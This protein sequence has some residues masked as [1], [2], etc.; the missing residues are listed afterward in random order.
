MMSSTSMT[1]AEQPVLVVGGGPVGLVM[2]LLLAQ[3]GRRSIVFERRP[4]RE[5]S[6]PKAH[7]LNPR[8]LE[9]CRALGVD[10]TAMRRMA[11][12]ADH[13][14]CAR[15]MTTLTGTE[16]GRLPLVDPAQQPALAPTPE[17]LLNLA[18]PLFES[19]LREQ[20]QRAALV[21]LRLGHRFVG[22]TERS[23]GVVADIEGPVG[24]YRIDGAWLVGADGANSAVREHLG[25]AM[26]GV[27]AVRPR[28]TIHFEAD[29]SAQVGDRP[30]IL[31]WVLD[32]SARGTFIAYDIRRTWVFTPRDVPE[33][34]D[35][36][37][38][39]DARCVDMIRAA[40][41]DDSVEITIRHVV[42][43]MMAAQ[44][45]QA[46]RAGRC[47]L[48]G[49]AA[50]RFPPTGGFGL[51]TGIQ[52]AHNLAWKLAAVLDG[53]ADVAL[54]DSYESERQPVAR[55]NTDR[56]LAN[57]QKLT[58]LFALAEEVLADGA[59]DPAQ[60]DALVAELEH[61]REH[62]LSEGLQLGFAYGPPTR[63][64]ADPMRYEPSLAPGARMPH[65][66]LALGGQRISTLDLLDRQR[67]SL[68]LG[69][70]PHALRES[71]NLALVVVPGAAAF[72]QPWLASP[73]L[74]AGGALLVRPDGH[75]AACWADA[76]AVTPE[77]IGQALARFGF[78]AD[79]AATPVLPAEFV[80]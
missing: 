15:F 72:E 44:V 40:L 17:P 71:A 37:D 29:L 3:H 26:E 63:G 28:I 53:R 66:W 48:A 56:S 73:L 33:C 16:F 5:S 30:A 67:F 80:P 57:A 6:A 43:W 74:A 25:I 68:L 31:Y 2:A 77:A 52:D 4:P 47:F 60:Q 13:A 55:L 35:R 59:P 32:P 45:A 8:S 38:Y 75:V 21:E 27:P 58:G 1:A 54:L 39:P 51:N 22:C 23:D 11:P 64:P 50:H 79:T 62:F 34:F 41:G 78:A 14:N 7:V 70:A 69:T 42:P 18:Q 12:H 19:F 36:A 46:Y 24:T 10:V 61:H 76:A 9:I 65:A 20:V 49:D